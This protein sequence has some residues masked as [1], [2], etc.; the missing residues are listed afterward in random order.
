[1]HISSFLLNST[2]Q[3]S[4]FAVVC[5]TC[6]SNRPLDPARYPLTLSD[7]WKLN[8]AEK[9]ELNENRFLTIVSDIGRISA[10]L[11]FHASSIKVTK[12]IN[13]ENLSDGNNYFLCLLLWDGGKPV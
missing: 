2:F 3:L 13:I 6:E 1:M 7:Q 8:Y 12:S 9:D 11:I 10:N 4:F 5:G